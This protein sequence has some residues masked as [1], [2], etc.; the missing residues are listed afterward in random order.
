MFLTFSAD[1]NYP[2]TFFKLF[3]LFETTQLGKGSKE[4]NGTKKWK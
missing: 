4:K 3:S 2:Q 1:P